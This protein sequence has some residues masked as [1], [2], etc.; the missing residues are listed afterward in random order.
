MNALYLDGVVSRMYLP[1]KKWEQLDGD[2]G[3]IIGVL[4]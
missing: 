4:N 3:V 1:E 2:F